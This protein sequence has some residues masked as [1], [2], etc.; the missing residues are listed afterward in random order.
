MLFRLIFLFLFVF[1]NHSVIASEDQAQPLQKSWSFNGPFGKFDRN[2]I[3]RGYIVYKEVCS[4]CHSLK[5][6][7]FRNLREIGMSEQIIKAI[8]ASYDY[9]DTYDDAGD[10]ISRKGEIQ[11]Y[12]PSPYANDKMAAAANNGA[13]PPDL[14]LIIKA[15]KDGANYVYSLLTGYQGVEANDEGLYNNIY[16]PGGALA[17][18]PP[19]VDG[20]IEYPDGTIN[21]IENMSHDVVNFLQWTAEPEMESRKKLGLKVM[22][23]LLFLLVLIWRLNKKIWENVK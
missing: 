15:R 11:D 1:F 7:A 12:F 17:M 9:E 20:L 18:A 19:L 4:S 8:A 21:S 2:S 6:I 3:G 10:L 14:S 5:R 22:I 13:I 16:F 23:F